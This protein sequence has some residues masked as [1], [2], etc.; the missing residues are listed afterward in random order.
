MVLSQLDRVYG[1][2]H[3]NCGADC[4]YI[5]I[6]RDVEYVDDTSGDMG[7]LYGLWHLFVH[8]VWKVF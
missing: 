7:S 5:G 6:Q 2:I 1:S 3:W 4:R 8:T